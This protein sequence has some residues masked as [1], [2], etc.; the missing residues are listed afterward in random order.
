[1]EKL[2][3]KERTA[4]FYLQYAVEGIHRTIMATVDDNGLP[5]TCA[6]D[7]MDWDENSLYFLTAIG[8][9]FYDRLVKRGY[10][11]LTAMEGEDTM[12]SVA[13]SIRGKVREVGQ[14]RIPELFDKNPYMKV[15]YPP[16][17]EQ[18]LTVFQIYEGSG[19]WFDLSKLPLERDSF[20][21]SAESAAPA[22][23]PKQTGYFITAKCIGCRS[24]VD[25]C[26]Q[27]IIL[28]DGVPFI[29]EQEH[30]ERCG[31]C[32]RVCPVGAVERR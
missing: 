20:A 13:L 24:C 22:A 1:M 31:N 29:I 5:V 14:D 3:M 16:G 6:I 10:V 30:C 17:T 4:A 28:T 23:R 2:P 8:K 9:N 32:M 11:A 15:I 18:A 21:F 7:L 27:H 12:S 26:P 19:E 25:V